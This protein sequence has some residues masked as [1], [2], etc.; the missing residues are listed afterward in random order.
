M[1]MVGELLKKLLDTP[2]IAAV[3]FCL[4]LACSTVKEQGEPDITV[5]PDEIS[6][7]VQRQAI[8]EQGIKNTTPENANPIPS[9]DQLKLNEKSSEINR[10]RNIE[11]GSNPNAPANTPTEERPRQIRHV[12]TDTIMR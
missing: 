2:A 8:Y 3:S 10:K 11:E 7:D 4:L 5:L 12:G 6:N 9:G 1:K